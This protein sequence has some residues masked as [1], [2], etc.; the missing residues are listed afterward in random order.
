MTTKRNCIGLIINIIIGIFVALT[1][2]FGL[3]IPVT[4]DAGKYAA[5]SRTIFE[6]GEWFKLTIHFEPYLQKPP[7][8]FWI[9]A[10][11][12]YLFGCNEFAFKLPVLL[13]SAIAIYS[14]YRFTLVFYEK[15]VARLA[16]LILGTSEF[17][18][19]L[20]ADI[21][22]DVL[23]T[24]NVIFAIW[25]LAE[26][27]KSKNIWNMVF[28][29]LGTGLAMISKGPIGIFVP[30]MA[31]M[32]H[33]LY[34]R[35]IKN[36]FSYKV[37]VGAFVCIFILAIGLVGQFQQFGWEAL[38]FFFWENNAGRISGEIAGKGPDYFFYFHTALYMYMPW[39]ILFFVCW[40]FEIKELFKKNNTELYSLGGIF[41]YWIIISVSHAQAPHYFMVLS[42]LMSVLSAK[43]LVRFFEPGKFMGMKKT[44]SIIQY[45][46]ISVIWLLTILLCVHCFPT[47][48][49]WF[50][51]GL[52]VL[53]IL[54][55]VP[56]EK[57]QFVLIV[58]R[59]AISI[60]A[61]AFAVNVHLLPTIFKYQSVIPA[62][63]VFNELAEDGKMLNTYNSE[64][65]EPFFYSKKSGHAFFEL[66]DMK[67]YLAN[68]HEEWFYTNEKGLKELKK[69]GLK[70][71]VVS[72][73]KHRGMAKLTPKF[74]N[75]ATR[76][77]SLMNKYLVKVSI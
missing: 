71:E 31:V 4:G 56:G 36:I 55:F 59:S 9:T 24:A 28:A 17:Y 64:F 75:P 6:T 14:T 8:L 50:W 65:F 44:V 18:F 43:W 76:Q 5:I 13:Y 2:I 49:I 30:A 37:I 32:S 45:F 68:K 33:L 40:F 41:F 11:F 15:K 69:S 23:L 58:R 77:K 27:F 39:A 46:T 16:A 10:P 22:T 12:F 66:E 48:N 35:R 53:F 7:L 52:I 38:I 19:L 54:L 73:F 25:Q 21:H 47:Q 72:T 26:Y 74:L 29:G 57:N 63:N 60:V 51:W 67:K 1:Y 61:L 34:T 62:C 42:P 70:M 20:H 3:F